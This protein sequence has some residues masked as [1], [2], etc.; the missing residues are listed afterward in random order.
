MPQPLFKVRTIA[1]IEA[2]EQNPFV[3][4]LAA[5][6]QVP[7]DDLTDSDKAFLAQMDPDWGPAEEEPPPEHAM[8]ILPS[9]DEFEAA[10]DWL[11]SAELERHYGT[12]DGELPEAE[13]VITPKRA[14]R[15][16]TVRPERLQAVPAQ[17]GE[18]FLFDKKQAAHALSCSVRSIDY[19]IARGDLVKRRI[20]AS[21]KV[22]RESVRR[23]ATGDHSEALVPAKKRSARFDKCRSQ[24]SCSE[25]GKSMGNTTPEGCV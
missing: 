8:E 16:K 13:G 6:Q 4:F 5:A 21:V 22:T 12:P 15:K 3:L 18:Q 20:G 10:P 7:T 17:T 9:S 14:A 19:L 2:V 1:S 24:V 23:Y 25:H 11:I